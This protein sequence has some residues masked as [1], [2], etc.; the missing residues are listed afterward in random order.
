MAFDFTQALR[1]QYG[2]LFDSCNIAADKMPAVEQL[3]NQIAA[4]RARYEAVGAKLRVPWYFIGSVHSMESSLNFK[5]HLHNGDPLTARTVQVPAGRPP[6]WNPPNDWESSAE[7]AL[8]LRNLHKVTDWSLAGTLYQL[9]GYNGWGYRKF[10]HDV[11]TPYL[12]SYS[13]HYTSGKYVADGTFDPDAV[14]KQCG[15]AVILRRMAEVG[16]IV[17]DRSGE[18]VVSPAGPAAPDATRF[19]PLVTYSETQKSDAAQKLQQALNTMPGIFLLADGIPG[20]RTS[21]A[22]R[23]VTGHFLKGDP[24]LGQSAAGS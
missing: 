11:F 7:D 2:Q 5:K 18:P 24:R 15:S 8:T 12:W 1:D 19:D 16:Q 9:E 17:F 14:S 6:V 4:N 21:D 3:V 22:F 10:H 23:K 13:N 20:K